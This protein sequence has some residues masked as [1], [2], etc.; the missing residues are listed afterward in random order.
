MYL[1]E[2]Q[3][4]KHNHTI[5]SNPASYSRS[6]EFK[7]QSGDHLVYVF[8]CLP[9]SLQ[10]GASTVLVPQILPVLLSSK[11]SQ[12]HYSPPYYLVI[13]WAMGNQKMACAGW[14]A[15]FRH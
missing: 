6:S 11:S 15:S 2:E 1:S 14:L 4:T 7:S 5:G 3:H 8:H 10:A 12:S 9:Q 13:L